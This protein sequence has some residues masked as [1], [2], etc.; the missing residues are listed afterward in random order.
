M[1]EYDDRIKYLG[2]SSCKPSG[3]NLRVPL[4]SNSVEMLDLQISELRLLHEFYC[5]WVVTPYIKHESLQGIANLV[6]NTLALI[7][8]FGNTVGSE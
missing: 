7:M 5:D 6:G 8:Q 3:V 1:S 2:S 4:I